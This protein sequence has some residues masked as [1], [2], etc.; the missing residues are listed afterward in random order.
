MGFG[1]LGARPG[2]GWSLVGGLGISIGTN[3]GPLLPGPTLGKGAGLICGYGVGVA[4]PGEP[5]MGAGLTGID[6]SC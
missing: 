5:G 4:V 1:G 2:I 6:C 3:G